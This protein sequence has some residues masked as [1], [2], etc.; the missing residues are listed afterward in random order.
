MLLVPKLQLG[1]AIAVKAPALHRAKRSS[2]EYYLSELE[3]G[4]EMKG[5]WGLRRRSGIGWPLPNPL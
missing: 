4:N 1:N 5:E 3:L 2:L